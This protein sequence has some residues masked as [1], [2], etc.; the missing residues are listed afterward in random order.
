MA[1][2]ARVPRARSGTEL[3]GMEAK[4]A[5]T[6]ST[7]TQTGASGTGATRGKGRRSCAKAARGRGTA[8]RR[9]PRVAF[10]REVCEVIGRADADVD[11]TPRGEPSKCSSCGLHVVGYSF[12][13]LACAGAGAGNDGGAYALCA[14]C[15]TAHAHLTAA[16]ELARA[17]GITYLIHKHAPSVFVRGGDDDQMMLDEIL[18]DRR[19][20]MVNGGAPP[21]REASTGNLERCLERERQP[22]AG[23][24]ESEDVLQYCPV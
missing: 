16:P 17:H 5:K 9:G 1:T 12:E 21:E 15:F 24:D 4:R 8:K 2:L 10:A 14:M 20:L 7:T 11:R 22:S 23:S 19:E 18:R 3:S 13:C 6:T